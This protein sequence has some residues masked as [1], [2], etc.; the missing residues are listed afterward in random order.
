M[1]I[2]SNSIILYSIFSNSG[3]KAVTLEIAR[4]HTKYTKIYVSDKTLKIS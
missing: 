2:I 3:K 1:S 4:L